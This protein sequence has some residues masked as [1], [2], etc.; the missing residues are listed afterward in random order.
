MDEGCE[1]SIHK[2]ALVIQ[3][4]CIMVNR[5]QGAKAKVLIYPL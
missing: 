3:Y 2:L 4:Q 1:K 5:E